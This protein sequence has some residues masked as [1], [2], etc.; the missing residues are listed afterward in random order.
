MRLLT[1]APQ[2]LLHELRTGERYS[3]PDDYEPAAERDGQDDDSEP[4]PAPEAEPSAGQGD[5]Q[6]AGDAPASD[7]GSL[8]DGPLA[9][10]ALERCRIVF[11][12][13]DAEALLSKPKLAG[14]MHAITVGTA[15]TKLLTQGL[16][17]LA[18]PH[19][20]LAVEV[21]LL[22]RFPGSPLL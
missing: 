20:A 22:P 6:Q 21:W 15:H 16:E 2:A 19:A 11:C 8:E 1:A 5:G 4:D 3:V 14:A 9:R 7:A 17:A 10:A 13:G 12:T 18:S